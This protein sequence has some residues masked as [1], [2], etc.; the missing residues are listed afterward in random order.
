MSLDRHRVEQGV[1]RIIEKELGTK[2]V[3]LRTVIPKEVPESS[4]EKLEEIEFEVAKKYNINL[5]E[6]RRKI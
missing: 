1:M 6:L 3:Y 4:P 5:D 2:K